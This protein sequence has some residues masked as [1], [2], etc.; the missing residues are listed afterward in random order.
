[1]ISVDPGLTG[2]GIALWEN[3]ELV[4]AT[5]LTTA[6]ARLEDRIFDLAWQ[7]REA[8]R[9][10]D[11][12]V[13]ERQQTYGGRARRGDANDLLDLAM[14]VGAITYACE[15]YATVELV[16]PSRWKGNTPKQVTANQVDLKLSSEELSRVMF[17]KSKKLRADVYDAIGIGL[18]KIRR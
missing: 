18:W 11:V 7:V 4:S 14:L 13:V 16:A 3:R 2:T 5:I 10:C 1:M 15:E 9:L 6:E 12:A 8:A 17:P